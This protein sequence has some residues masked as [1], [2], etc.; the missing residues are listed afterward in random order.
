MKIELGLTS[1][2]DNQDMHTENGVLPAISNGERIRN[3]VEEIKLADEVGLDVYGLGEHHR[4]DYAVS[5]PTTVL[6]AAAAVTKNIKLSS[7]V[8]VLSS[9]DPIRVYQQFATIDAL[10]DGRA[11][12]MAVVVHLLNLSHYLVTTLKTTNNFLMKN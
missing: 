3:V 7:A 6:A 5:S 8:T 10:S 1:F 4:P 2:A 9:D 11:E 12:I